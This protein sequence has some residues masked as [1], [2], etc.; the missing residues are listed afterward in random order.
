MHTWNQLLGP[1]NIASVL[2][3]LLINQI[4]LRRGKG[5]RDN[6]QRGYQQINYWMSEKRKWKETN[7]YLLLCFFFVFFCAP[8]PRVFPADFCLVKS[9]CRDRCSQGSSE[10]FRSS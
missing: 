7:L 3:Q 5:S 6:Q 8:A 4:P 1:S 10:H 2:Q 9:L